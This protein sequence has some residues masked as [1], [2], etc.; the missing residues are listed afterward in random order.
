MSALIAPVIVPVD[1]VTSDVFAI[2]ERALVNPADVAS[3]ETAEVNPADVASGLVAVV[4]APVIVEVAVVTFVAVARPE[5]SDAF[6]R[7]PLDNVL[8]VRLRVP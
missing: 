4:I 7:E 8:S 5:R 1:E 3:G 2:G 6:A